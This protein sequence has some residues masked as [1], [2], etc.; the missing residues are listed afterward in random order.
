M[1]VTLSPASLA[2]LREI[3]HWIAQDNPRR[4]VTFS[5]ELRAKCRTLATFAKRYPIVRSGKSGTIH[6]R[7]VGHYLI[8]YRIDEGAVE[9]LRI[10]HGSRDWASLFDG[11]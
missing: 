8:F 4:A 5:Q 3:A 1:K 6:K 10:I 11:A 9:V 7:T 2:D